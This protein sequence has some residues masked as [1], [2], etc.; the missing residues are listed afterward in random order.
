PWCDAHIISDPEAFFTSPDYLLEV[1]GEA[2]RPDFR[3]PL[4]G[5]DELAP[6]RWKVIICEDADEY[7]RSDARERSGPALGR[8]LNLTDG[9]L[10][11]GA[12]TLVVLTTNDSLGR[13][14]PAVQRPGRCRASI[15]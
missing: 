1:V 13:I 5:L 6:R 9:L 14:H 7:L 8:L 12:R 2:P 10:G 4:R 3:E 15:A 11:E